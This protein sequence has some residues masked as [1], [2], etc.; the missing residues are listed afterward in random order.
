M[1]VNSLAVEDVKNFSKNFT[2]LSVGVP[3][4]AKLDEKVV[5]HCDFP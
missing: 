5:F 1:T 2:N 3:I 4:A